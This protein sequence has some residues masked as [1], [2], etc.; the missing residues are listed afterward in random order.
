MKLLDGDELAGFIKEQ[1]ASQ[2]RSFRQTVGILPKLGVVRI[3][4][5]ST[6]ELDFD[7]LTRYAADLDIGLE[8]HDVGQPAAFETVQALN[9]DSRT[10]GVIIVSNPDLSVQNELWN[11][12]SPEKNVGGHGAGA[13][14][15]SPVAIAVQWLLAGYNIN[16]YGK[17]CVIVSDGRSDATLLSGMWHQSDL[18]ASMLYEADVLSSDVLEDAE[19]LVYMAEGPSPI[20]R[21]LIKS[22][23]V[24]VDVY[25]VGF[26][27]DGPQSIR[28]M[29][30][31]SITPQPSG[32][33]MLVV[34]AL[35]DNVIRA[36][37]GQSGAA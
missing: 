1:Q 13:N 7:E 27:D 22:D 16:L 2:V 5:A 11:K 19:V 12:I 6:V 28:Q 36:A 15:E 31:V 8:I 35:F 17:K 30:G 37:R 18:E 34:C 4:G 23:V 25:G 3:D 33:K 21:E 29:P 10:H 20:S 24:I 14:F 26:S 32:L 9:T